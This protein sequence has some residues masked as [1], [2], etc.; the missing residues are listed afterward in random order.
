M[1][2][3]ISETIYALLSSNATFAAVMERDGK[4]N[5]FPISAPEGATFPL[6]T[7]ILGEQTP[8]SKEAN[9][10]TADVMFWFGNSGADYDACCELTDSM[11]QLLSEA[12][13]FDFVAASIDFNVEFQAYSGMITLQVSV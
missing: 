13:G 11:V 2:K 9:G 4:M 1:F 12:P 6:S 7:Y 8:L 10:V 5:L 3:T